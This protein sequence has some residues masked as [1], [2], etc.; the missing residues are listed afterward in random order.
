MNKTLSGRLGEV[1][2]CS[3]KSGLGPLLELFI[4][5][6]KSQFK[7]GFTKV[8]VS[9]ADRLREWLQGRASTFIANFNWLSLI[10]IKSCIIISSSSSSSSVN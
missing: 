2:L 8:I 9:R 4:T 6:F 7:L 10:F 3:S 5:K 1:P